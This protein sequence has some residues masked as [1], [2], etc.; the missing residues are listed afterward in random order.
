[1]HNSVKLD[2][3]LPELDFQLVTSSWAG[4]AD[5]NVE[6]SQIK[7]SNAEKN[8]KTRTFVLCT[9]KRATLIDLSNVNSLSYR[10]PRR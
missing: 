10:V 5:R 1:M 7:R 9:A 6:F 4:E 3:V 8:T 2:R